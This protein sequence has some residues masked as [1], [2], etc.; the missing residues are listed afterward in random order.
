MTRGSA[1]ENAPGTLPEYVVKLGLLYNFAKYVEWPPEAFDR[2][3]SPL[4]LGIVGD[5]PFG[6]ELER[7][8]GDKSVGNR[9]FAFRRFKRAADID[10]CHILFVPRSEE[11]RVPSILERAK[12]WPILTVGE[13]EGF[14][15]AGGMATILIAGERPKLEV[16]VE[17]A[18]RT[19][20][21]IQSK[22]LRLATIVK[23]GK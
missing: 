8:L 18:E 10:R 3:D 14:P 11:E 20:L 12:R 13:E 1:P 7:T 21:T 4:V 2:P 9:A 19:N 6:Q 15:L 17:A 22:L 23:A 5:D 16:N